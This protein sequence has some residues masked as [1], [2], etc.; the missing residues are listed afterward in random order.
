MPRPNLADR[1]RPLRRLAQPFEAAETRWFGRSVLSVLFR[2]PVLVLETRGRR[3]G[4]AR[5]TTLAYREVDGVLVVVGG[6][7]GQR[8]TPDWVANL[9]ADPAVQVTRRW[10]TAPMVAEELLGDAR[11]AMWD[12]LL[13]QLPMI[14]TYERRAGHPI[15]VVTLRER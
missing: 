1:L 11:Q 4:R 8:R 7:G 2:Q 5:R 12:R 9:R 13:P 10:R 15:P 14:A 6:A 3:S